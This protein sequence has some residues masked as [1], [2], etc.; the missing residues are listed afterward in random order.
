MLKFSV[1][2]NR[3]VF[4]MYLKF[5]KLS[6]AT[7]YDCINIMYQFIK[8][9]LDNQMSIFEEYGA[10]KCKE[11]EIAYLHLEIVIPLCAVIRKCCLHLFY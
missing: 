5:Y 11:Y 3:R 2:L 9:F 1:Y 6:V 8:P 4:V 7:V 10:F